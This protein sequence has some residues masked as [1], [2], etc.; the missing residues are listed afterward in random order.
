MLQTF[1]SKDMPGTQ[2]EVLDCANKI[3]ALVGKEDAAG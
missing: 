2:R 1:A 3:L